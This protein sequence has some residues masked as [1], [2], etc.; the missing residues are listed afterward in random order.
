MF[1]ANKYLH[2]DLPTHTR[3]ESSIIASKARVEVCVQPKDVLTSCQY[4]FLDLRFDKKTFYCRLRT[5][6]QLT[7]TTKRAN[8]YLVLDASHVQSLEVCDRAQE[9]VPPSVTNAFIKRAISTSTDDITVL[10]FGLK[11][12]A[13]L[14]TPDV[15]LHKKFSY[16]DMK[17]F[18]RVGQCET[19][20]VYVLSSAIHRERLSSLC[21]ALTEDVLEPIPE[22]VLN[23]L[24]PMT[25]RRVITHIDELW[26]SDQPEN[27]PPYD[28]L[29]APVASN[30]DL[31]GQSDSRPSSSSRA[32]GKRRL[33][34]PDPQQ[35]LKRQLLAEKAAPEPWE[36]AIVA[37]GAQIAALC[38][39]LQTLREEM[40]Q[41]RHKSMVDALTQTD[42]LPE[43]E[44]KLKSS[45]DY[46]S[47]SQASTVE[48]TT[49]DRLLI[50][51]D[52]ILDE[53][54]Q[55]ALLVE[56][57]DYN[58]QQ[59]RMQSSH[60]QADDKKMALN[61]PWRSVR[62]CIFL[63]NASR[64]ALPSKPCHNP[65]SICRT[66]AERDH[67]SNRSSRTGVLCWNVRTKFS[68]LGLTTWNTVF[69]KRSQTV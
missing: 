19:F 20:K 34:S 15:L 59:V 33:G 42:P 7:G 60:G 57:L 13:P 45:L 53:Q 23:N 16:E 24:Y 26:I 61:F 68:I 31:T 48:N 40:Q 41:F 17:A 51:E 5:T 50:L 10:R 46:A 36:L 27:P 12:H 37:Q 62:P 8:V 44:A 52:S 67:R 9:A 21:S 55:R 39:E 28:P 6:A 38:A 63:F 47:P 64:H 11:S 30:D 29:A 32:H 2:V 58:N 35:T 1:Q 56:K 54:N 65:S 4:I 14:V 18:L 3:M 25:G 43:A 69:D 22:G 66:S 49:E